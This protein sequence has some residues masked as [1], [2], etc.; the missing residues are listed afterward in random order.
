MA[1][2]QIDKIP[3]RT[4][5]Y[6]AVI[7]EAIKRAMA[8]A[9]NEDGDVLMTISDVF[10][11][12]CVIHPES[13]SLLLGRSISLP[14]VARLE[15]I[16]CHKAVY[17]SS[18]VDRYLSPYGGVISKILSSV[19]AV[20]FAVDVGTEDAG[21]VLDVGVGVRVVVD[22]DDV[23]ADLAEKFPFG[24]VFQVAVVFVGDRL[25][26]DI[27]GVAVRQEVVVCDPL[28]AIK[29]LHR[30]LPIESLCRPGISVMRAR[31]IAGNGE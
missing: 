20:E 11:A 22:A 28:D 16:E 31:E 30:L 13:F 4:E 6:E 24:H 5:R 8:R 25:E 12:L 26:V 17:H 19:N 9:G 7:A 15:S 27:A 2:R 1:E 3:V 23:R 21:A 18:E 10:E 29:Q 14:E